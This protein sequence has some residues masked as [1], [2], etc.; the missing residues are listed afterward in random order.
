MMVYLC[1][2]VSWNQILWIDRVQ[3]VMNYSEES[4]SPK[5]GDK[6]AVWYFEENEFSRF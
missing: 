6:Q 4:A 2:K 1:C 3:L 5:K